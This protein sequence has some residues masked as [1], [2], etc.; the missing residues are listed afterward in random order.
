MRQTLLP[1]SFSQMLWL[2]FSRFCR[3]RVIFVT[4]SLFTAHRQKLL[5]IG[6]REKF[7]FDWLQLQHLQLYV[8]I[9]VA[10]W[11]CAIQSQVWHQSKQFLAKIFTN[12]VEIGD[13]EWRCTGK[14]NRPISVNFCFIYPQKGTSLGRTASFDIFCFKICVGVFSRL[15]A[16]VRTPL[17]KI[18]ETRYSA[19]RRAC[20]RK[21]PL[22]RSGKICKEL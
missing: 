6:F 4:F 22:I 17:Q 7:C 8:A 1:W 10:Q 21:K 19:R 20:V 13:P 9:F 15:S 5:F 2:K 18:S 16:R 14:E 11:S 3:L 12:S